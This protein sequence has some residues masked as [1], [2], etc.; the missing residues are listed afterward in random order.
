FRQAA[1]LLSARAGQVELVGID[2]SGAG[3]SAG[4]RPGWLL[5]TGTPAKLRRVWLEYGITAAAVRHNAPV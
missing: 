1:Q 4:W 3:R 2:T 5:L